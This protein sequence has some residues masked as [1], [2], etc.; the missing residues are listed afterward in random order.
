MGFP[1]EL[2]F[3]TADSVTLKDKDGKTIVIPMTRDWFVP[4]ARNLDVNTVKPRAF[5]VTAQVVTLRSARKDRAAGT[6]SN[7]TKFYGGQRAFDR[8]NPTGMQGFRSWTRSALF[9]L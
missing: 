1:G 2:M 8:P 3:Y 9:P 6:R 4:T 5:V 7:S